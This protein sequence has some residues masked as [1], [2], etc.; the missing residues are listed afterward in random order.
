MT[1][2]EAL[3]EVRGRGGLVA[4]AFIVQ[5]PDGSGHV[6]VWVNGGVNTREEWDWVQE[7]A[8][9]VPTLMGQAE[10]GSGNA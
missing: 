3:E 5:K 9:A 6:Q 10:K 8:I 4:A 1:V 2:E 7:E